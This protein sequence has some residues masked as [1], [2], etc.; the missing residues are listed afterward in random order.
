METK[1]EQNFEEQESKACK[2]FQEFK[3]ADDLMTK[4]SNYVNYGKSNKAFIDAFKREHNT[5]QQSMF[6]MFL[7]LMEE[8]ANGEYY[9]D[10]RNEASKNIAKTLIK[11]FKEAK[12]QEY[13]NEG[14]SEKRAEDYVNIGDGAK[15]SKYLPLI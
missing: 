2:N 5:L 10:G 7:E 12:K 13:I 8:M 6:K 1:P 3:D 15:P 9:T 11:G 14:V 4:L